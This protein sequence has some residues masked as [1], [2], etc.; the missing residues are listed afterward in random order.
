MNPQT[1]QVLAT[2]KGQWSKNQS[3]TVPT[4]V[5]STSKYRIIAL[6]GCYGGYTLPKIVLDEFEQIHPVGTES[7][8]CRYGWYDTIEFRC[9]PLMHEL[10]IKHENEFAGTCTKVYFCAVLSEYFDTESVFINE[11]DGSESVSI[12]YSMHS[13][14][15][16]QKIVRNHPTNEHELIVDIINKPNIKPIEGSKVFVLPEI[17]LC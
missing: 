8:F 14:K 5:S 11:Y 4:T 9:D 7:S 15:M 3:T 6:N 2:L 12:N 17:P 13:L 10:I 1:P 16:I